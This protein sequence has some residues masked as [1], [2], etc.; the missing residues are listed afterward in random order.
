MSDKL[1]KN[2]HFKWHCICVRLM[3]VNNRICFNILA[4]TP[5]SDVQAT[6][7]S[8][9]SNK[10]TNIM[11]SKPPQILPPL[12]MGH[13]DFGATY[14]SLECEELTPYSF[15]QSPSSNA[16]GPSF[17]NYAYITVETPTN[18]CSSRNYV[19]ADEEDLYHAIGPNTVFPPGLGDK[20][21]DRVLPPPVP[22]RN[23]DDS[24]NFK[25]FYHVLEDGKNNPTSLINPS[26]LYE[27]P[28]VTKYRAST[29]YNINL[30]SQIFL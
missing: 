17:N 29:I 13:Y 22:K 15:P 7:S 1:D 26:A 8:P 6:T 18:R 24:L 9:L 5:V 23:D 28:T 4:V 19:Y 20:Q 2:I 12:P 27:D 14:E 10:K 3:C 11:P 16:E 21:S 25:G 30:L